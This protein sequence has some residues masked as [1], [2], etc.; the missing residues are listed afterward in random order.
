MKFP[1]I[2]CDLKKFGDKMLPKKLAKLVGSL[3][4]NFK[5]I[6]LNFSIIILENNC[7]TC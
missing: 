7:K 2:L 6:P 3:E 4:L 1:P 5:T